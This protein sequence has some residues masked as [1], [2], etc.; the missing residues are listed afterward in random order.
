MILVLTPVLVQLVSVAVIYNTLNT[1]AASFEKVRRGRAAILALQKNEIIFAQMILIF[2][3]TAYVQNPTAYLSALSRLKVRFKNEKVWNEVE[4]KDYPELK[5]AIELGRRL[6]EEFH[7]LYAAGKA[8]AAKGTQVV[9][10]FVDN[11]GLNTALNLCLDRR[12]LAKMVLAIERQQTAGQP[13]LLAEEK[14]QVV[15]IFTLMLVAGI[16]VSS[17]M[18]W[19]FARDIIQRLEQVS[20]KAHMLAAGKTVDQGRK[21]TDEISELDAIISDATITLNEVRAREAV[22][23]DNAA[24][25]IC[26]LDSK[27]RFTAVGEACLKVWGFSTD[28]LLGMSMLSLLS[29]D[30][31]ERTRN[32]FSNI[33]NERDTEG[34]VENILKTSDGIFKN[35]VWTINWSAQDETYFCVV[36]DVTELRA[37]EKLKQHFLSIASHDLRAPLSAVSLNI[38]S[39]LE[40]NDDDVSVVAKQTLARVQM[41]VQ[42]LT[43]L[44]AELLELEKLEAGKLNLNLSPVA[45]SDVCEEAKELL[46][47]MAQKANVHL[48]NPSGEALLHAEEKRMVQMLTNLISNAIKFS[49]ANST[50]QIAIVKKDGF[51]EIRISDQGPGIPQEECSLIFERFTQARGARE[52]THR[53]TGLGLA[54]VRALAESHGGTVGVESRVGKGSTFFV[55]IPLAKEMDGVEV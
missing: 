28:E 15:S 50:V 43:E 16:S 38:T 26:S 23:L 29:Q 2:S 52:I 51:G 39:L 17:A 21:G 27:L 10:K 6:Q 53:G 46:M 20:D 42:R 32:A 25:V 48:S 24:D 44:V 11:V 40:S 13:A 33:A 36:H 8:A 45:A 55:R 12:N 1:A 30:T 49:P 14:R 37:I 18:A 19:L 22:V 4:L 47:G 3:D 54:I 31:V 35:F 7:S 34:R 9:Q 5:D 41:S